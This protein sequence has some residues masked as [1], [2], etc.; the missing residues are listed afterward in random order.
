MKRHLNTLR[1]TLLAAVAVGLPGCVGV[2][3]STIPASFAT[4]GRFT[5]D[6]RV[7]GQLYRVRGQL[8]HASRAQDGAALVTLKL[9]AHVERWDGRAGRFTVIS[10]ESGASRSLRVTP[11]PNGQVFLADGN[12]SDSAGAA[13]I[14]NRLL[15]CS[16]HVSPPAN[17]R[18]ADLDVTAT[19]I[20]AVRPG[21]GAE[22]QRDIELK[23]PLKW[24]AASADGKVTLT[25]HTSN[26]PAEFS[27]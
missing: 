11:L 6:F 20:I 13:G 21:D 4:Q 19:A 25:P 16:L 12:A 18:G 22:G 27:W 17:T 8:E 26:P 24:K 1:A 9:R 10:P 3:H 14:G 5:P 23:I 15:D 7:D 2:S